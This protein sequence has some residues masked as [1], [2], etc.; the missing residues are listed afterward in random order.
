MLGA[1]YR[2]MGAPL[3]VE[4]LSL[5]DHR[6]RRLGAACMDAAS[7]EGIVKVAT[8]KSSVSDGVQL[9]LIRNTLEGVDT[10]VVE[11]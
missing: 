3:D 1:P 6:L 10:P 2:T 11:E 8:A 4:F 9:P 5:S 7:H